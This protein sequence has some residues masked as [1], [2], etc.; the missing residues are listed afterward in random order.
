MTIVSDE[1]LTAWDIFMQSPIK[2]RIAAGLFILAKMNGLMAIPAMFVATSLGWGLALSAA[3]LVI[4]SIVL[5]LMDISAGKKKS[6]P[7]E[8]VPAQVT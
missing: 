8:V 4:T 1:E 7:L 6:T 2:T 5:C 3:A